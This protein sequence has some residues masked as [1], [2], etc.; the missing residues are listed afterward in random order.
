MIRRDTTLDDGRPAWVLVSQLAH[1]R[2]AGNLAEHWDVGRYPFVEPREVFVEAVYRH[3]DG[4]AVWEQRPEVHDG[5]PRD[6]MEMPLDESLAIWRRSIAVAAMIA[7]QTGVIVGSHFRH[8]CQMMLDKHE[9]RHDWTADAEHLAE[10]FLDEQDELR[11]D[12]M[13]EYPAERRP[14]VETMLARGLRFLQW[15]DFA[16]LWLCCAE[17]TESQTITGPDDVA[18]RFL[19]DG[20][21]ADGRRRIV[22]DPW[23]LRGPEL[24]LAVV[25][26]RVAAAEYRSN[27]ALAAAASDQVELAWRLVP[28]GS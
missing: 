10:D 1:A 27:E 18:F 14:A 4:W 21:E 5:T 28:A 9:A 22:L 11:G 17:R 19:P 25:G 20:R 2:L 24:D 26:R 7:P 6:F 23:P 8:L 12:L 3:D 16:S 13:A 15:F